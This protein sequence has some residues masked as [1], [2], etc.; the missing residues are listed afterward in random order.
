MPT[1]EP[2]TPITLLRTC[3]TIRIP[4]GERLSLPA[5]SQ[6]WLQQALGGTYTVLT[7]AGV[8]VR[9]ASSDA[10][11]LGQSDD[12]DRAAQD[13]PATLVTDTPLAEHTPESIEASVWEQLK[14]CFDPEIPV[15]IVDLGLVYHCQVS[16]VSAGQY[17][18]EVKFTLTAPG[19]GMGEILKM[20]IEDKLRCLPGVTDIDVEVVF[21]PPW[22]QDMLSEAAKLELGLL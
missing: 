12:A 5:G 10:D 17:R 3:E 16:S 6:V 20:D 2:H 15:N 13:S 22:T 8:L 4:S 7:D 1:N 14:T 18:V 11:A 21:E 19:C 9:I